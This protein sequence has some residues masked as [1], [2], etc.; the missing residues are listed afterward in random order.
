MYEI[1]THKNDVM[2]GW[3]NGGNKNIIFSG[4]YLLLVL[5]EDVR[6]SD[7]DLVAFVACDC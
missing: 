1:Q 3:M 2:D 6:P 4:L 5:V 7:L